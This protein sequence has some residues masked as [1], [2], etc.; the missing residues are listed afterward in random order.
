M[1]RSSSSIAT[2]RP[3]DPT[4]RPNRKVKKPMLAPTSITSVVRFFS[5]RQGRRPSKPLEA[6]VLVHG[7][8]ATIG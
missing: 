3:W 4:H 1:L 7:V 2:T 5:P 8:A 6:S